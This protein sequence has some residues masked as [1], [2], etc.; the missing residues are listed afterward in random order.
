M[1]FSRVFYVTKKMWPMVFI[2][3]VAA[4]LSYMILFFITG[5]ASLYFAYDFDIQAYLGFG[6]VVYLTP[7]TS[8]NW[9]FDAIVTVLLSK[10]LAA[11]FLGLFSTFALVMIRCRN[12][13]WFYFFIWM[14][15]WGFNL[16]LGGMVDDAI[17]KVETYAV[18]EVMNFS[19]SA[20]II[21]GF[22]SAYLMYLLGVIISRFYLQYLKGVAFYSEK[23]KVLSVLLTIVFPWISVGL[24][25]FSSWVPAI[26]AIELSR[27][28]TAAVLILPMFFVKPLATSPV[29][30]TCSKPGWVDILSVI[31]LFVFVIWIINALLNHIVLG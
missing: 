10:P 3:W 19:L 24:I 30:Y 23:R 7:I 31:P 2:S 17:F 12:T 9:T 4:F 18:A 1:A 6:G 26:S 8:E 29:A 13:M 21:S 20:I 11:F 15:I 25:S 27:F 16:S 28:A 14:A 22:V 5:Y